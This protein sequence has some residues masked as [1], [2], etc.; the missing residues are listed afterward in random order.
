MSDLATLVKPTVL[1]L[2]FSVDGLFLE[3]EAKNEGEKGGSDG[4][5]DDGEGRERDSILDFRFG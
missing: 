2:P 4:D 5:G 3:W 1:S